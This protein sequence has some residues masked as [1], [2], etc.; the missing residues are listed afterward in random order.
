MKVPV[1]PKWTSLCCHGR[2]LHTWKVYEK[3]YNDT[4][5]FNWGYSWEYLTIF[6]IPCDTWR[7]LAIPDNAFTILSITKQYLPILNNSYQFLIIPNKTRQTGYQLVLPGIN[8][9]SSFA[10]NMIPVSQKVL[11]WYSSDGFCLSG[12]ITVP[13]LTIFKKTFNALLGLGLN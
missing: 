9:A 13:I 5:S 2:K 10:A 4:F 3:N 8:K 6:S 12:I 11:S 7:Y 1:F